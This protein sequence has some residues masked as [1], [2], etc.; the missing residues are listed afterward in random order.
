MI[1]LNLIHKVMFLH[2]V[3]ALPDGF[4]WVGTNQGLAKV[5]TN[6]GTYQFYS[7]SNS[8]IPGESISPLQ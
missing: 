2:T 7:P 8:Q 4:A 3:V 5:N 6:N 1:L